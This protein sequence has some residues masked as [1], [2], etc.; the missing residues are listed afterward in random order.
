VYENFIKE[1]REYGKKF[2]Q[3]NQIFEDRFDECEYT[4]AKA[5]FENESM[6]ST[7]LKNIDDLMKKEDIKCISMYVILGDFIFSMSSFSIDDPSN[8]ILKTT[9]N[10]YFKRIW[11][12]AEINKGFGC[13]YYRYINLHR[14]LL[15]GLRA[16]GIVEKNVIRRKENEK[17]ESVVYFKLFLEGKIEIPLGC[18]KFPFVV[19]MSQK[20]SIGSFR[21]IWTLKRKKREMEDFPICIKSIIRSNNL[22]F[23]LDRNIYNLNLEIIEGEKMRILNKIKCINMEEY[24]KKLYQIIHDISYS[25]TI[26]KGTL[27]DGDRFSLCQLKIEVKREFKDVLKSF[28]D[29]IPFITISRNIIN[30]NYYLPCFIDNR[31]RQYFGTLLSPTFYKIFRYLYKFVEKR[32][33]VKLEE[34]LFYKSII[35]YKHT[36][37]EF[38]KSDRNSYILMILFME[39]GKHFVKTDDKHFIK[40]EEMINLGILNYKKDKVLKFDE[41]LYVNKIENGIEELINNNNFDKNMIIFKDATASGLQNYGILM[42]YNEEKLKYLNLDGDEWCDTYQYLIDKFI[43]KEER[44]RKRKYWKSTIMTIPYNA[45]WYSCFLKFIEKIR[46]DGIEYK[47][48]SEFEKER[49]KRVH[50]KFYEEIKNK[51]KEEF[52]TNKS[53]NFVKFRYNKWEISNKLEYK[54]TYKKLRDKY[55][56]ITYDIVEDKEG[57]LRSMEANNMHYLDAKLVKKIIENFDILPIHD[58]FGIRLSE[59]HL[60]VDEINEYYS[61][62]I[63][64]KIYSIHIIK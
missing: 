52:Y 46:E 38:T 29:L 63:G 62:I 8:L 33:F 4:V 40:T 24:E 42:G 57:T 39:I 47:D 28:Q 11:E 36:V 54:V 26:E 1:E 59:L 27:S 44:Y 48:L 51:V 9:R 34:S 56:D 32:E 3:M 16:D 15:L 37:I 41:L 5:L 58:C 60:V 53:A 61:K 19:S 31:G 12:R 17:W 2:L 35:R 20:Y 25:K 23:N 18:S 30:D 49:I 22:M 6:V 14:K 21:N 7:I 43:S 10:D 13:E 45:V 55:S 64:K 50:K